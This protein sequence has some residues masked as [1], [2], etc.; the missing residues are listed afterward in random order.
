MDGLRF[1]LLAPNMKRKR[2][3][4]LGVAV[5]GL[6]I[7]FVWI[8]KPKTLSERRKDIVWEEFLPDALHQSKVHYRA[9]VLGSFPLSEKWPN[10]FEGHITDT[11]GYILGAVVAEFE[12]RGWET[13]PRRGTVTYRLGAEEAA[14]IADDATAFGKN[15]AQV[16]TNGEAP[17]NLENGVG[18]GRTNNDGSVELIYEFEWSGKPSAPTD[19]TKNPE[20]GD[21]VRSLS[22][23]K[24]KIEANVFDGEPIWLE[25][26]RLDYIGERMEGKYVAEIAADGRRFYMSVFRHKQ[27]DLIPLFWRIAIPVERD[28]YTFQI[29]PIHDSSTFGYSD[30]VKM[31]DLWLILKFPTVTTAL[32]SSRTRIPTQDGELYYSENDAALVYEVSASL[33]DR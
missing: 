17:I 16:L 8:A 9:G 30:A 25:A 2:V 6:G 31:K 28:F 7:L 5:L 33:I 13:T 18:K 27:K 4:C 12:F 32:K 15:L 14:V 1:I 11:H 26:L 20:A 21:Q 22:K 29:Q 10:R 19:R 3:L 24:E 23:L